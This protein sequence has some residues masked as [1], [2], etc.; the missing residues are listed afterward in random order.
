MRNTGTA[1]TVITLVGIL[2]FSG[3]A[4]AQTSVKLTEEEVKMIEQHREKK[5]DMKARMQEELGLTEEQIQKLEDHRNGHRDQIKEYRETM[6]NLREEFKTETEKDVIDAARI[7]SV[8][9]QMKV[10]D[11]KM[12]DHRLEGILQLREIL[13]PEQFKQFH[14]KDGKKRGGKDLMRERYGDRKGHKIGQRGPEDM[15]PPP[16]PLGE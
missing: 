11:N 14:K 9:A 13:T 10:L 3:L 15:L 8:H 4:Y 6:K 16:P 2:G 5:E 1:L 12:A 7:Q